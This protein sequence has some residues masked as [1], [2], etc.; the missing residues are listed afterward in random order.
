M[1]LLSIIRA[2]NYSIL[3]V[4]DLSN[5]LKNIGAMHSFKTKDKYVSR[6]DKYS[7]CLN[8]T[9][10]FDQKEVIK[11]F[12]DFKYRHYIIHAVFGSGKT[13]LL[14]GMLIFGILKKRFVPNKVLFLSFNLSIRNEIKR[15]LKEYGLSSKISVRTFDS[16]IYEIAKIAQYPYIDLPN[17]D[18]KRKFVYEKTFD[19]TF[20]FIPNYQ[21]DIIFID[22]CQDLERNTLTILHKFYPNSKF[23]FSG[24]IFQSIQKEPRESILWHFMTTDIENTYK[25]YMRETPRV[26]LPILNTIKKALNSYYPEFSEKI[27][28]WTSGNTI[29]HADIEWRRLTSYNQMFDEILDFTDTYNP[30]QGMILTFSSAITVRGNMGDVARIRRYMI[31]NDLPVNTNHKRLDPETYFLSTANS[32]KGLERDYVIIFLTFPLERAFINLSDDIVINLITVALTRAKKK[33]FMYVPAYEDKFS[34]VLNIFSSCPEP[35]KKKIHEG[36]T[37][38]EFKYSD[39]IN[40]E[41]SVTELIRMS[42]VK[43]DTRIDLKNYTKQF[44]F[45]K[46]FNEEI[47]YNVLPII[48]EEE[49]S[50]V[51]ILIENLITSTWTGRFPSTEEF[52]GMDS[53]PMFNHVS[54]NIKKSLEKYRTFTRQNIFNDNIQFRGI[55]LYSQIHTAINNKI[56]IHLSPELIENLKGYWNVLKPKCRFLKPE[57]E[58][59][60]QANLKMPWITGIADSIVKTKNDEDDCIELIEIKASQEYDWKDNALLQVLIYS[61]MTGKTWSRLHLLN[62]FR[63]EKVSY[64]FN[65]KKIMSLRHKV[66]NDTL[67]YNFNS[68][69]AKMY[70]ASKYK[71]EFS[72]KDTL[73]IDISEEGVCVINMVSPIKCELVYSNF[74]SNDKEKEKGMEKVEKLRSESE[75]NYDSMIEDLKNILDSNMNRNKKRIGIQTNNKLEITGLGIDINKIVATTGYEIDTEKK[76]GLDYKNSI[77]RNILLISYLFMNR[78]FV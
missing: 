8:F 63:N 74:I 35:E 46:I 11:N 30:E 55:Y 53:N 25:I 31:D 41:H 52:G 24:D 44:H 4:K 18:G 5:I 12:V 62:P 78:R 33:V 77:H 75:M 1:S 42:I 17:F 73:F 23:V 67:I 28:S 66:I 40:L 3:P 19:D 26:P 69:M 9:W 71:A 2:K 20:T 10:R 32:S 36:K 57:G 70:G 27:N 64:Y 43:Y 29:S 38:K 51:G 54:G 72:I 34:R 22:E 16:V 13:T 61:L 47:K 65:S 37:M 76:Y 45:S 39:Y 56:F 15:K 48:T 58:V 50:F 6:I 60:I 14:L 49:R 7:D 59:K 68:F 21:P